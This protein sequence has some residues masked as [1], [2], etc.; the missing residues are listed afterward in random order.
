MA[1]IVDPADILSGD[2]TSTQ[3]TRRLAPGGRL[4][5]GVYT[6]EAPMMREIDRNQVA[7]KAVMSDGREQ[8]LRCVEGSTDIT[9]AATG[10]FLITAYTNPGE[11]YGEM[12]K[13]KI[14]V[15]GRFHQEV[16]H[17]VQI[18]LTQGVQMT[19]D[20]GPAELGL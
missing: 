5:A 7:I 11:L 1:D 13:L 10:R 19:F 16:D 15:R 6:T 3:P 12:C 2:K 17:R 8:H 9:M 18:G 20:F 14:Y 4:D